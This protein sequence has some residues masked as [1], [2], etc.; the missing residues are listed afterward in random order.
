MEERADKL[1][2][3]WVNGNLSWVIDEISDGYHREQ[4]ALLSVL[5][6]ERLDERQRLVFLR[7]LKDRQR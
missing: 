4:V 2:E 5:V 6:Y 7:M 1:A 3:S